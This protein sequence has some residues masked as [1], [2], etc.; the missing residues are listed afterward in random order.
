MFLTV[1]EAESRVRNVPE[2]G[3]RHVDNV[4]VILC[5]ELF[6]AAAQSSAGAAR[7]LGTRDSRLGGVP[8]V[9]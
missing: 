5:G 6:V 3:R 4:E 7:G 8:A 9:T 2:G 1:L